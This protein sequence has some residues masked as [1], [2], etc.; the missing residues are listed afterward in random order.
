[1]GK[2]KKTKKILKTYFHYALQKKGLYII[3][4]LSVFSIAFLDGYYPYLSGNIVDKLNISAF[5]DGGK[6]IVVFLLMLTF[7]GIVEEILFFFEGYIDIKFLERKPRLDYVKKIQSLDYKFHSSKSTGSLISISSRINNSLNTIF[8][9]LNI[10]GFIHVFDVA[11]STFFLYS[12]SPLLALIFISTIILSTIV[13]YPLLKWN[14]KVRKKFIN[15]SDKIGGIISDNMIGFETVKAF[16]Q[17]EY[18]IERLEKRFDKWEKHGMKYILTFRVFDSAIYLITLVSTALVIYIAYSRVR[19]GL[20]T[21]GLLVTAIGYASNMIWKAFNI[22]Y[23]AKDF[24]KASVDLEKFVDVMDTE[25]AVVEKENAKDIG[26]IERGIVFEDVSFTY[27]ECDDGKER[28]YVL[29]SINFDVILDETVALVGKSGSGKST[30]AKLLMRY[31][32]VDKGSITVNG[33]DVRDLKLKSLRKAI[34]LVPQDPVMFNET[35]KYNISY[36]NP[37]ASMEDII[38][39]AENASLHQFIQTLP[40]GYETIVGERGIKLSGG[41]RQ[42]LAIARVMLENPEIIIFDEATSQLDSE[43][44]KAIQ[45]AFKNLTEH[46]TTIV[47]AHRLSTIMHADKIVVF[48]E[49]RIVETG[50]HDE[51]M[52]T[53]GIY[54]MLWK[55]QTE[56]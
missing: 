6:L 26:G 5:E 53:N 4:M 56:N 45:E 7:R 51:L 18:E 3:I 31:Y 24:M 1:M 29:D 17:E 22:V 9:N 32:D 43:N 16:G 23:K 54:S 21:T 46:K 19:D 40:K 12:I 50:T 44:E 41:Q 2:N 55:L 15:Q 30:L 20:W 48:D 47:I 25:S 28:Q 33:I 27:T 35:I 36:G 10:W 39:A 49:G 38:K 8:N 52:K 37:D 11:I 34:G 14:V 42:R 13:G